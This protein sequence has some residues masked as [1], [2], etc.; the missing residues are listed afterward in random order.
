MSQQ[1][2]GAY[3]PPD[4]Y[5]NQQQNNVNYNQTT[6]NNDDIENLKSALKTSPQFV[7]C[8]YCKNQAMTRIEKSCSIVDMC[9]CVFLCTGIGWVLCKACRGKD[10][11]CYDANHYCARCGNKLVTYSAC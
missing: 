5:N 2:Q 10:I 1:T 11:N 8:P 6:P 9:V 3:L 7:C 4:Q